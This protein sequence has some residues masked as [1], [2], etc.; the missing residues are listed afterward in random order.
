M[1][2]PNR[3]ITNLLGKIG[4]AK[5]GMPLILPLAALTIG[6]WF[7]TI[8][9]RPSPLF[10]ISIAATILTLIIAFMFR[11]PQRI[12][13]DLTDID[14]ISPADGKVVSIVPVEEPQFLKNRATRISIFLALP[15]VHVNWIPVSGVVKYKR[16]SDGKCLPAFTAS[17]SDKNRRVS[18]GIECQDGFRVTVAQITGFIARR[19]KCNLTPGQTVERGERYGMIYFGSRVDVFLPAETTV[20]VKKGDRVYGGITVIG[21]KSRTHETNKASAS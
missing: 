3:M 5:E 10:W 6:L 1:T 8:F 4:I 13:H 20:T 14:I 11:N 9:T 21:K 17:A 19:I 7:L 2:F 12:A 15:D 18:V 16:N